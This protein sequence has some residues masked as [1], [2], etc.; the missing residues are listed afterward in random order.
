MLLIFGAW[1]SLVARGIWDAEVGGSSPLAPILFTIPKI[2]S[3]KNFKE[4]KG[5]VPFISL[6][7]SSTHI[8]ELY[9]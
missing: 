7:E 8:V 6:R 9:N 3:F 4:L 2:F 1:R 5:S